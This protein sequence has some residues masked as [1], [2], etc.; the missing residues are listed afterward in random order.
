[1]TIHCNSGI[2]TTNKIGRLNGLGWVWYNP[3]GI[4]NIISLSEVVSKKHEGPR[5]TEPP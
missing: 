4:V 2:A 1:M 3:K 5:N